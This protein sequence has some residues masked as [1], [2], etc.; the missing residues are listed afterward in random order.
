MYKSGVGSLFLSLSWG[1]MN[2]MEAEQRSFFGMNLVNYAQ[3]KGGVPEPI[4]EAIES[5]RAHGLSTEGIF[6]VSPSKTML[7]DTIALIEQKRPVDWA[8]LPPH[9]PC[10]VIKE[11]LREMQDPL[12][13]KELYDQ[14][15]ELDTCTC[16]PVPAWACLMPTWGNR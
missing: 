10:S 2:L 9:V 7:E 15:I 3:E 8:E 12:F 11:F 6:R 14:W 1:A 13:T 16:H 4:L 5:V